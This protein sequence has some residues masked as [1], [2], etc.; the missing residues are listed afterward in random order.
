MEKTPLKYILGTKMAKSADAL[1]AN[2]SQLVVVAA[3]W[4]LGGRP[5]W[6]RRRP[7]VLTEVSVAERG[8]SRQVRMAQ[9]YFSAHHSINI[10]NNNNN[11]SMKEGEG[12]G[13]CRKE[14]I[15]YPL[16]PYPAAAYLGHQED[17]HTEAEAEYLQVGFRNHVAF[18]HNH[19]FFPRRLNHINTNNANILGPKKL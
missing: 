3:G 14:E 16:L 17:D 6:R 18:K 13:Y 9:Q 4:W 2:E 12:A 8:G 7:L 5:T 15:P 10:N 11:N 19:F 1:A